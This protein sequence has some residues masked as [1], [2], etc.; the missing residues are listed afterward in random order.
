MSI[1][2]SVTEYLRRRAAIW[3]RRRTERFI[4]ALP[5]EI[6]KDIGWPG[7]SEPVRGSRRRK[8]SAAEPPWRQA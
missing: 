8:Q 4:S 6:Q 1:Q 2:H 3:R 5:A 7:G